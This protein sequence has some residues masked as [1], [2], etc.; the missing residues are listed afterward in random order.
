MRIK[1]YGVLLVNLGTPDAPTP[2]A[3]KRFLAEFLS[4]V[5]VIDISRIIW[6]PLLH[7]VI[8]PLRS[9]KVAKLY[10]SIWTE[11]GSPLLSYSLQQQAALAKQ[12]PTIPVE[13]GMSYGSPSVADAIDKLLIQQ[14]ENIIVL[15]LYPQYSCSTT[16][17]VFDAIS[18][19]LKK[20]RTIPG[21]HFIRSYAD[22]PY[23]IEALKKSVE[24]SFAQYGKPDR[25]LLSYHGIPQRYAETG[26]IYPQQCEL[27]TRLFSELIDFPADKIIMTYQSRFGREPWLTPYTDVTLASLAKS[28]VKHVQLL[29]PGF[30][31][32]CLET[33]EEIAVQNKKLF[34]AAGG[35][36]YQ[37]IPALN[38]SNNHIQLMAELITDRL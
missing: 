14:V 30:S 20:Y 28:G 34:Y 16:A 11:A 7:L 22:H 12:L 35:E 27:T 1:K 8:L 31:V 36:K 26:D 24:L 21:L 32:D 17:S 37:Y 10:Q 4:D 19:A 2:A 33:L 18:R 38:A 3:V 15:P 29:C 13:L 23:Y 6:K 9:P 5:R 25:L